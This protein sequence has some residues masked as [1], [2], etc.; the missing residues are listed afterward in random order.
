MIYV[1]DP[2]KAP[3]FLKRDQTF[4]WLKTWSM[5]L[6][7]MSSRLFMQDEITHNE[8]LDFVQRDK[9]HGKSMKH[10]ASKY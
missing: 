2:K 6:N 4:K 3:E 7:K 5:K 10:L 1:I 9:T 8:V